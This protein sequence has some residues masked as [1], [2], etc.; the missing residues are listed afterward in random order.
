MRAR[1]AVVLVI[2]VAV[3]SLS[4]MFA[5]ATHQDSKDGNDVRGHLDIREVKTSG[6]TPNPVWKIIASSRITTKLLRDRGFF[7]VYLDTFR[8]SHF[9]Y[10]VLVSSNGSTMKGTLWRDRTK[11]PDRNVGNVAVWRR[12]KSSVT[13]R[14]PLNKLNTGGKA[15]VTYRW[16]IKTLFTGPNCRRVCIDRAPNEGALTESNGKQTPS[17]TDT[18]PGVTESPEPPEPSPTPDDTESPSTSPQVTPTP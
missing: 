6:E 5:Q 3:A 18:D 13:V 15:Q 4:T 8:D 9:D 2:L 16:F 7:L 11:S 12:D 14:V 17:P 1:V 10:Y